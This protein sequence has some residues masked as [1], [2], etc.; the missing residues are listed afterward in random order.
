MI[1][2]IGRSHFG[3]SVFEVVGHPCGVARALNA[4]ECPACQQTRYS[5]EWTPSQWRAWTAVANGYDRCKPCQSIWLRAPSAPVERDETTRYLATI[6]MMREK[7]NVVVWQD[8]L[9]QYMT[10]L[11]HDYRKSLS[12]SG[13]LYCRD[14]TDPVHWNC[15][16]TQVRYFDPGNYVYYIAFLSIFEEL[17][18]HNGWN[19]QT[20]GDIFESLLG[21]V[22]LRSQS[23]LHDPYSSNSPQRKMEQ[24]IQVYVYAVYRL[25][26]LNPR[27]EAL[28]P[29]SWLQSFNLIF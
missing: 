11:G 18:R 28:H 4:M 26:S 5:K 7:T 12:H 25:Y 24:W 15:R 16:D 3:S 23:T 21:L 14:D 17:L 13:A 19:Q 2:R 1:T 10:H 22:Y 9:M 8:F 29:S 27:K 20:C 6:R